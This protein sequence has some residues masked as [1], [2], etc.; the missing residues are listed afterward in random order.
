MPEAI[1]DGVRIHYEEAGS[2]GPP[3]LFVHGWCCDHGYFQP[4]FDHFAGAHRVVAIDQ[5]GFGASDRPEHEY[6]IEGFADD[7][8]WLCG[9]LGLERPVIVGHSLG[10][11]VALATA[12]RFP[13]LPSGIVLC[14]PGILFPAPALEGLR[15][16]VDALASDGYLESARGMISTALFI[17]GDDPERK[18]RI[19]DAMSATP[20]HVMHSAFKNL[21]AFDSEAAAKACSVPA[22]MIDAEPPIADTEHTRAAWPSVLRR[23]TLGA[24]HFHQLEVPDQVNALIEGFLTRSLA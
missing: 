15:G 2:G 12:A 3:L 14:D 16:F 23:Q 10:G 8:G 4:Q 5:R 22:L 13:E 17:E 9:Q 20:Q 1:R 18:R 21:I 6:S 11:A 7:V 24:G 19:V